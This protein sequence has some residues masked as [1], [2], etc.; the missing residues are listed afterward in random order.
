MGNPM[1]DTVTAAEKIIAMIGADVARGVMPW[2]V[3][4]FSALHDFVDANTYVD[5]VMHEAG[6][7]FDPADEEQCRWA[8]VVME[9]VNVALNGGG[10][11]PRWEYDPAGYKRWLYAA[12]EIQVW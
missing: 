4:D 7:V 12:K 3:P 6:W 1:M 9:L 5:D 2:D 11:R 10:R 8:N